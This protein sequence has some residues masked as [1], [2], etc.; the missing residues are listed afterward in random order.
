MS[1]A[2]AD[3][4]AVDDAERKLIFRLDDAKL[5]IAP[6]AD[7]AMWFKLVGISIDNP[8]EDYPKGDNVQTVERWYPPDIWEEISVST[9][10]Q[11]LDKIAEGLPGK[12]AGRRYTAMAQ[13]TT[14]AAWKVV[15]EVCPSLNEKQAR[16]VIKTWGQ[17][18]RA[19]QRGIPRSRA[20]QG[21]PRPGRRQ[22][23]RKHVEV[24]GP[25]RPAIPQKTCRTCGPPAP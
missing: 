3:D 5:N 16:K 9:A 11:I 1:Q 17:E 19:D 12:L 20:V 8:T 22:P 6:P 24:V 15:V 14:R 4:L 10:N 23:P 2:E 7:E 13:A 25:S 21:R 18:G